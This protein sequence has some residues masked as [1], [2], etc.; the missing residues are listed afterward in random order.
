MQEQ[1]EGERH[2]VASGGPPFRSNRVR[3]NTFRPIELNPQELVRLPFTEF[4]EVLLEKLTELKQER[5]AFYENLRKR[6]AMWA[7]GARALLAILG[8]TALLLTALIAAIRF[9]PSTLPFLR[10]AED[11]KVVLLWV[12]VIYAIMGAISFYERGSDK[13]TAYFRQIATILTIRDLWTK[14]Q[15]AVVKELSA[16]GNSTV[17]KAEQETRMRIL[18]LGE[19]FCVDLDKTAAGELGE[20]RMEFLASLTELDAVSKK[21]LEEASKQLEERAKAA[22]KAAAEASAAAKAVDDATKPGFLNLS[23]VGD[24]DHEVVVS[25]GGVEVGRSRGKTIAIERV[26]PGPTKVSARAKKGSS[27]LEGA[28]IVDVKPG[29]QECRLTLG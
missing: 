7:N 26:K 18:A 6:N 2:N 19:A 29:V 15:F 11:D 28:I 14:L 3:A 27:M 25:I 13:T 9:A 16:F 22:E 8:A 21:A 23:V 20:F 10:G 5:S 12:L 1:I 4:I 24:F 17:A